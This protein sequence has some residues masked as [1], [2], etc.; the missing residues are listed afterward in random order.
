MAFAYKVAALIA[1][2]GTAYSSVPQ[3]QCKDDDKPEGKGWFDPEALERG[4]KAIREIDRSTNAKR[5]RLS[6]L[7]PQAHVR[8]LCSPETRAAAF[9]HHSDVHAPAGSQ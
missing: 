9:R 3:A 4:A 7:Q 5:V 8:E 2:G 1:A 6:P